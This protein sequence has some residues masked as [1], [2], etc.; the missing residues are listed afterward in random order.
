MEPDHSTALLDLAYAY[1][2]SQ[3]LAV[4][5]TLRIADHLQPGPRSAEDLARAVGTQAAP[6]ARLLRLLVS[7]GIFAERPGGIFAN[8]PASE[9]LIGDDSIRDA[10]A[11]A[12]HPIFWNSVGRLIDSVRTG[13]PGFDAVFGGGFFDHLAEDAEAREVFNAGMHRTSVAENT[14]IARGYDFGRFTT[15]A[16]V[17]GGRGGFLLEI[18]KNHSKLRGVLFDSPEAVEEACV[19]SGEIPAERYQVIGGNFFESAPVSADA[20]L[21]KRVLHDWDDAQ[22]VR[23]LSNCAQSMRPSDTLIVFD[24]ILE[25]DGDPAGKKVSDVLLLTLLPGRERTMDEFRR[26]FDEAGLSLTAA[27]PTGTG[28]FAV[29]GRLKGA[30]I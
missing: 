30:A 17:G 28:L 27:H 19:L 16:D 24:A 7:R 26:I 6:L 1:V 18:L 3:G 9:T 13:R 23:I 14:T 12:G 25:P 5:A 20:I 22:C 29:E 10:V 4:A 8:T 11:L 15:V 2:V 21:L